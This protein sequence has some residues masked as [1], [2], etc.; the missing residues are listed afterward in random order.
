VAWIVSGKLCTLQRSSPSSHHYF[1]V[2]RI[3]AQVHYKGSQLLGCAVAAALAVMVMVTIEVA[4]VQLKGKEGQ[5]I[6]N[7][8]QS[9]VN[10]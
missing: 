5:D 8:D 9:S 2:L 7:L 6:L 4:M 10:Q 1:R 3:E